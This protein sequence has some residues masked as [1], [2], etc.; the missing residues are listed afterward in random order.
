MP[1]ILPRHGEGLWLDRDAPTEEALSV[2]TAYP[3]DLTEADP[4]SIAVNRGRR[5]AAEM[6]ERAES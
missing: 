2:L 4:V 6:V 5:D 1:V 3:A